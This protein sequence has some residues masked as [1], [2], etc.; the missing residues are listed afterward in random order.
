MNPDQPVPH[1]DAIIVSGGRGSRLG[2]G[3]KPHVAVAGSRLIDTALTA[4]AG[5]AQVCVV[6]DV[7][8]VPAS[9]R[10]IVTNEEP[11]L[12]GPAAALAHGVRTL[13]QY[14][15]PAEWVLVLAADLPGAVAGVPLLLAEVSH[16]PDDVAAVAFIDHTDRTQWLFACYR[17]AALADAVATCPDATNLSIRRLVGGLSFHTIPGSWQITGD[18]DTPQDLATWQEHFNS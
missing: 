15:A 11:R 12:G 6:G 8:D 14:S 10:V 3:T 5:A 4:V 9:D 2:A 1:F 7:V 18:V 16:A 13:H 17:V